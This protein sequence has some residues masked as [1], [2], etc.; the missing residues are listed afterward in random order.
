M[1]KNVLISAILLFVFGLNIQ[2]KA[3]N[4]EADINDSTFY[5]NAKKAYYLSIHRPNSNKFSVNEAWEILEGKKPCSEKYSFTKI[6]YQ[7]FYLQKRIEKG[8]EKYILSESKNEWLPRLTYYKVG[9][10]RINWNSVLT[11]FFC[12]LIFIYVNFNLKNK[13]IEWR[14]EFT[15]YK[16]QHGNNYED[17]SGFYIEKLEKILL[18]LYLILTIFCIF[19]GVFNNGQFLEFVPILISFFILTLI[20]LNI[21]LNLI[22]KKI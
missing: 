1:K 7:K 16:K 12:I 18:P 3:N 14:I 10:W 9:I 11:L 21:R 15:D 5:E 19:L 8:K 4:S 17:D 6:R 20:I 13:I 22:L 2:I